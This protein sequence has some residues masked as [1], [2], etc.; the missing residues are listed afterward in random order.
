VHVNWDLADGTKFSRVIEVPVEQFT[1]STKGC[2][3]TLGRNSFQ[4]DLSTYHVKVDDPQVQLDLTLVT[5]SRP[6]RPG[7]G[8]AFGPKDERYFAWLPAVPQGQ[9]GGTIVTGQRRA[10]LSGSGYHDHNWGN[11]ALQSLIHDWYWARAQVGPYTV[12]ASDIVTEQRYG[13]QAWPVFFLAKGSQLLA[14]G[15]E[16]VHFTA[17]PPTVDELTGKPV[18]DHLTWDFRDGGQ[19]YRVS[20]HR[21]KN[22]LRGLL[23]DTLPPFLRFLAKLAGLDPAYLRF[24][25][26]VSVEQLE[27]DSVISK[28][29]ND[30]AVWELMYLGHAR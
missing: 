9:V 27:G 10:T 29:A 4:G 14:Q 2:D 18:S 12:I 22:L 16:T 24:T 28:E 17:S 8:L 19:R 21:R 25:G 23:V 1:A 30:A 5:Q 13:Y 3:V 20:F 7:G 11:A 15:G 6:W 26:E